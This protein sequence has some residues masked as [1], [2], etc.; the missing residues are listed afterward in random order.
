MQCPLAEKENIGRNRNERPSQ[1]IKICLPRARWTQKGSYAQIIYDFSHKFTRT[2]VKIREIRHFEFCESVTDS[3]PQ[4]K[5][6]IATDLAKNQQRKAQ[7]LAVNNVA[8]FA[9]FVAFRA[10]RPGNNVAN[11]P[12]R[13]PDEESAS[14]QPK[15]HSQTWSPFSR[16]GDFSRT[17]S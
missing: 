12:G 15:N 11:R 3:D 14:R 8:A 13:K 4:L 9:W 10:L 16:P 1:Q 5:I 6:L 7:Q 2:L 17:S